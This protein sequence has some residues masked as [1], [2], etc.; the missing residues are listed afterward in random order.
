MLESDEETRRTQQE[1]PRDAINVVSD[2]AD[3]VM[4][5]EVRLLSTPIMQT[6]LYRSNWL[7]FVQLHVS[8]R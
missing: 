1:V 7:L 2:V 6:K 4:M 5:V 8:D 3:G